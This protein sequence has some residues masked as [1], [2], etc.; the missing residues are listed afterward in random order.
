VLCQVMY[1]CISPA[2]H[3]ARDFRKGFPDLS[4]Q[5]EYFNTAFDRAEAA[6]KGFILP[7]RG[8]DAEYDELTDR[9]KEL[10]DEL[11]QHLQEIRAEFKDKRIE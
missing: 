3:I 5:L 11:D 7:R 4:Q 9:I 2:T 6:K 1:P 10:Q 8:V